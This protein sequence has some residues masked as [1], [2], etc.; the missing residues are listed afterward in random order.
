MAIAQCW[1]PDQVLEVPGELEGAGLL[2]AGLNALYSLWSRVPMPFSLDPKALQSGKERG[3][4]KCPGRGE[5][6]VVGIQQGGLR[7]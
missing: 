7:W 5:A 2:L 3:L 6:E 4:E 1:L